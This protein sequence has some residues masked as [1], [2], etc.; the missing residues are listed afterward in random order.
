MRPRLVI[1]LQ[2][3]IVE[4]AVLLSPGV[5]VDVCWTAIAA[6]SPPVCGRMDSIGACKSNE[7]RLVAVK[8]CALKFRE[9][10]S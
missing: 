10:N 4:G 1:V 6:P 5:K 7:V 3:T 8:N 2:L 9:G